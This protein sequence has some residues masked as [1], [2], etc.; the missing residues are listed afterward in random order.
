MASNK[1]KTSKETLEKVQAMKQRVESTIAG[2]MRDVTKRRL[3]TLQMQHKLKQNPNIDDSK[4]QNFMHTYYKEEKKLLR[5]SRK[6]MSLND[7]KLLKVIGG[8]KPMYNE[9]HKTSSKLNKTIIPITQP[10]LKSENEFST[11][12]SA[13]IETMI[14]IKDDIMDNLRNL[15]YIEEEITNCINDINVRLTWDINSFCSIYSRKNKKWCVG[16]IIDIFLHPKS[17]KEWLT[18]RYNETITKK[19]QRFCEGIKPNDFNIDYKYN[20][21]IIKF[22]LNKLKANTLIYDN[23]ND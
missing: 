15:G 21:E 12:A 23:L 6:Q 22:I 2:R 3:R 18:V 16:Q 19:I 4:K 5:D 9:E 14:N 7:F 20:D 10:V 17:G 1:Q 8:G 11:L 13:T